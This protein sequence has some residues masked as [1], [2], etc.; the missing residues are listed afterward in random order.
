MSNP[1]KTKIRMKKLGVLIR[2]AR[3]AAG[4]QVDDCARIIGVSSERVE[5]FE[6][7]NE[8]PSLPELESLAYYLDIPLVHFWGQQSL[9]MDERGKGDSDHLLRLVPLRTRMVSVL[10]RKA[11]LDAGLSVSELSEVSGIDPE[12]IKSYESGKKKIPLPNLESLANSLNVE[13]EFFVDKSG[14]IG[15]WSRRQKTMQAFLEMPTELQN[16]VTK[17]VNVPYLE[18]AQR[19]SEMS[20]EKLR[21]LAEGLLDI[22]L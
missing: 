8:A 4:K 15:E 2:D 9:S 21:S 10:L 22:T 7:G 6:R 5:G 19:L 14:L 20:V 11:R 16:F 13:I 18:I 12:E 3:I 17:P 1:V